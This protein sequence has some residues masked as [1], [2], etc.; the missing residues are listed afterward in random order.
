MAYTL[1]LS[2]GQ[3]FLNLPDQ[4]SDKVSTSL[5][6][7]GKNVNAYGTDINQ[8]YIKLL[9]NFSNSVAPTAPI[10][11]QLWY[12]SSKK[13]VQVYSSK[14]GDW[15][16]VG[17]PT[18]AATRPS[19]LTTGDLW[20]DTTTEQLKFQTAEGLVVIGPSVDASIGRSGWVNSSTTVIDA[21]TSTTYTYEELYS[22]DK[23]MAILSDTAFENTATT[24][25]TD[26][27]RNVGVGITPIWRSG[28]QAEFLGTATYARNLMNGNDV[29]PAGQFLSNT[30]PIALDFPLFVYNSLTV[31]A[32]SGTQDIQLSA[33]AN[34]T[35][36]TMLIGETN[37][38]FE[39]RVTSE[40]FPDKGPML[41][42]SAREARL[43]IF[44]S[45][46]LTDVD[47]IGDVTVRGN[48]I[49]DGG[50]TY[51]TSQDLR[52]NDKTIQLNYTD[53]AST[54]F[55]AN[56]SGIEVYITE[57]GAR[58]VE[59]KWFNTSLDGG[60]PDVWRTPNSIQLASTDSGIYLFNDLLFTRNSIGSQ[61]TSAP[62][63]TE[64]GQLTSATIA[65]MRFTSISS[66]STTTV[67]IIPLAPPTGDSVLQIGQYSVN[68]TVDFGSCDLIN[69]RTPENGAPESSVV[70]VGY[71]ERVLRQD[72]QLVTGLSIDVSGESDAATP[73]DP[74]ID[75]HITELLQILYNP[76]YGPGYGPGN[77]DPFATPIGTIAKV[78]V[79]RSFTG[80][81]TGISAQAPNGVDVRVTNFDSGEPIE[82]VR[83]NP[84][85][86]ISVAVDPRFI[87]VQKCIKQYSVQTE[88]P[89]DVNSRPIWF[90]YPSGPA[91]TSSIL[92]PQVGQ[93]IWYSTSTGDSS[94]I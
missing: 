33:S 68:R 60:I 94:V 44:N 70:T 54:P 86:Q 72:R 65:G 92:W 22:N 56:G 20:Y 29:I 23:L 21:S 25:S 24:T 12:D 76:D 19:I 32:S 47:I 28:L 2:N 17:A 11:G 4:T 77:P 41:H 42:A 89:N 31:S 53:G 82:V 71:V 61:I 48:L 73:D 52:V 83:Y 45:N 14:N 36:T 93:A 40:F 35:L 51:I 26:I 57:V 88:D 5:T 66:T 79:T 59:F 15:K 7:I 30:G 1:K 38:N 58:P 80:P 34:S 13:Q 43:G 64:I 8:N 6:L 91:T 50:A 90:R 39:L 81:T 69:A 55:D 74:R 9:E 3:L 10:V 84:S 75:R 18:I 63:L 87:T 78:L 62:G 37:A 85:L 16:P 49:V 27:I 46:P 67:R